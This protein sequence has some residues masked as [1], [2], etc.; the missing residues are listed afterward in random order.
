MSSIVFLILFMSFTV[1]FQLTFNFIYGIFSKKISIST[2]KA[3]SKR[4]FI[5]ATLHTLCTCDET[6]FFFFFW[7][8]YH[9]FP[10]IYLF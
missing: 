4:I 5:L 8:W 7:V 2:K 10:L 3:V 9:I 6:F 1:L